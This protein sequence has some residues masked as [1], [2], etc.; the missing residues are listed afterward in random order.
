MQLALAA[1]TD[2]DDGST[3]QNRLELAVVEGDVN[4]SAVRQVLFNAFKIRFRLGLFDPV[5]GQPYLKL[6]KADVYSPFAQA[7]NH[8]ATRQGLVLLKNNNGTLPLSK[9]AKLAVVGPSGNS[10]QIMQGNYGGKFCASGHSCFPSIL[11]AIEALNEA[12]ASYVGTPYKGITDANIQQAVAATRAADVAILVLGLN[13][14]FEREQLDRVNI[15]LPYDQV[16]AGGVQH[17]G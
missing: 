10:T 12:P 2:I 1:E 11:Q 6:G 14:E 8:V 4:V 15:T 17:P 3:Y 7:V 9:L 13:E 16:G 5:D